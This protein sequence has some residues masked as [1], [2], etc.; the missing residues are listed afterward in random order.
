M[1]KVF[2]FQFNRFVLVAPQSIQGTD[3]RFLYRHSTWPGSLLRTQP[4]TCSSWPVLTTVCR[5][6]IQI[7]SDEPHKT[8]KSKVVLVGSAGLTTCGVF[9]KVNADNVVVTHVLWYSVLL[10]LLIKSLKWILFNQTNAFPTFHPVY[11]RLIVILYSYLWL[12]FVKGLCSHCTPG[13]VCY[14]VCMSSEANMDTGVRNCHL[15]AV[16]RTRYVLVIIGVD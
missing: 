10:Y 16:C 6:L 14:Y 13:R 4:I 7:R 11:L 9:G 3:Y 2:C 1:C 5:C 12:R 8:T 15:P